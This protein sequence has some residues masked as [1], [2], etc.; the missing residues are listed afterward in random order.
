MNFFA[1]LELYARLAADPAY[2]DGYLYS[3]EAGRHSVCFT[4]VS[5]STAVTFTSETA[6]F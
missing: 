2:R 6:A 1:A 5:D 3:T 4:R